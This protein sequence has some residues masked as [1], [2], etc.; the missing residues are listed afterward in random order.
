M[1]TAFIS[2]Y[3]P[4]LV[5]IV[6]SILVYAALSMLKVIEE[7]WLKITLSIIVGI[8]LVSSKSSVNYVF[9]A[10]PY[11]T[12][13]MTVLFLVLVILAFVAKDINTFKKPLAWI[14]FI[15]ALL[16]VLFLAFNQFS[17]LNHMLPQSSD[18]GLDSNLE[19]FKD[20]IYSQNFKEGLVFV[21]SILVVGFFMFKAK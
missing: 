3:A 6:G 8:I 10:I 1:N 19:Q 9:S 4:A 20:F 16:I 15:L 12:V 5:F 13:L 21:I 18:S 14:G 2:N 11:I 7:K 17:V